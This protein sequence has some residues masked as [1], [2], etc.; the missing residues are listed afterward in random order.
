[1]TFYPDLSPYVYLRSAKD[2][3][4]ALNVGWLSKEYSYPE[5]NVSSEFLNNLWVH[6]KSRVLLTR[7]FSP[8]ELSSECECPIV[9]KFNRE[10]LRLG[11]A[12]IRVLAKD[13]TIFA[14]PDMIFHYV[15]T[16]HYLPPKEFVEAVID[17]FLPQSPEYL[18]AKAL[19]NW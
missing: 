14:A 10:I 13:G 9:A 7:G 17:G 16:H 8:C 1:M 6:C 19:Y 3:G 4:V 11:S 15:I 2:Y 5:G 12:E 18:R